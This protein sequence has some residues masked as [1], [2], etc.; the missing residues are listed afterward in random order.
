MLVI[1]MN[2]ATFNDIVVKLP[3][4]FCITFPL[5]KILSAVEVRIVTM[6]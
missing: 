3:S 6:I 4:R 1:V 5:D 2:E